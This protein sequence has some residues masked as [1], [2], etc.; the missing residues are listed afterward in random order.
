V[1][2]AFKPHI[3]ENCNTEKL[4]K[5]KKKITIVKILIVKEKL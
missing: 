4:K 1:I 5:L 2:T 3:F